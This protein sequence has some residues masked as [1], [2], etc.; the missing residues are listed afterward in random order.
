M[1]DRIEREIE[2]ILERLDDLPGEGR[3]PIPIGTRKKRTAPP[4]EHRAPSRSPL[5]KLDPSTLLV[6]GAIVMAVGLFLAT[7]ADG[8]IW[9]AFA[10]VVL[11][12]AA[13]LLSI[14][15]SDRSSSSMPGRS[16]RGAFWRDRYIEYEPSQPSAWGRFIRRFRKH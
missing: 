1:P 12:L 9:L 3:S 5:P 7:V 8:F 11:F 4:K 10:G 14:Y 2:E 16:G 15:R 13:F 6:T